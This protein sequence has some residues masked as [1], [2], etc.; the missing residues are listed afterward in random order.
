MSLAGLLVAV[1]ALVLPCFAATAQTPLRIL[2]GFPPGGDVDAVARLFADKLAERTGRSVVVENRTGATGQ[3][4][5]MALKAA[6]PDGNTLMVIPATMLTLTPHTLKTP[7][8]DALKDFVA[9]AHLGTYEYVLA[10]SAN[11]PVK[12]LGEW[13]NWVKSDS[14]N[15]VFGSSGAG[16][17][18]HFLGTMLAQA[19]GVPLVHVPYRGAM[20][21]IAD[22]VAGQVPVAFVT[23]G[24]PVLQHVKAGKLRILAHSGSQRSA[25]APDIPT[26]RELGYP[27]LEAS[28]W[29]S[30]VAPAGIRP[31][32]VARYNEILIQAQRTPAVRDRMRAFDLEI[33]ELTPAEATAIL[34]AEHDRWG[35]VVKASGFSAGG[36]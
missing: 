4:A 21:V 5:A 1:V 11:V 32:L 9:V 7:A 35:Q 13:L 15:A 6:P 30:L 29:N 33:R 19:I 25:M 34:K 28:G 26:F 36:Q 8:Y 23:L 22:L 27:A 17:T 24:A 31:E 14:K 3:I 2:V 20:P 16:S 12:D 10:A 18:V